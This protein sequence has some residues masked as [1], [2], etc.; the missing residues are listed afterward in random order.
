MTKIQLVS[1]RFSELIREELTSDLS[2]AI[3]LNRDETDE[4]IC[5][6][7][8]FCDANMLMDQAIMEVLGRKFNLHASLDLHIW[9]RA[10]HLSKINEFT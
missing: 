10:W 8:D 5:H 1:K 9:D 7:Q 4:F 6:T 3:V 2:K